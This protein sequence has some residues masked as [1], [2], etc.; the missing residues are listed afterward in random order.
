M[1]ICP[2][3]GYYGYSFF[4]APRMWTL[5]GCENLHLIVVLVS[6][7]CSFGHICGAIK[8]SLSLRK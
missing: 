3:K 1:L 8:C 6:E 2:V 7:R 4:V 5:N